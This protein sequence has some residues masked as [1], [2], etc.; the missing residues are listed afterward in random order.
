MQITVKING[1]IKKMNVDAGEKLSHAL[2]RY[3]YL[4][5]KEGC[6][7]G[8]CGACAIIMNGK[9]VNSCM[10][11]APRANNSEIITIEG[12]GQPHKP[13]IIQTV[14]NE[15][16]AIQCGYCTPGMIVSVYK[17]LQ[18]NPNP[19]EEEI[20]DALSGNLCRCTGYIKQIEAVKLAAKKLR[21]GV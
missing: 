11:Y 19:T 10:I 4:G 14:F 13:H 7:T 12:I 17:L 21:E 2:R 3:N 15:I 5:V 16:G 9:V 1:T 18:D 20:R 6:S 8:V